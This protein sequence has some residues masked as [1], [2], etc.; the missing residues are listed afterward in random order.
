MQQK[1]KATDSN[2]DGSLDLAE[3]Q[4]GMPGLAERFSTVDANNDGK[5]TPDE[6]RAGK[7]R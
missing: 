4:T 7:R 5:V 1:F 3:A 2:G 6:L